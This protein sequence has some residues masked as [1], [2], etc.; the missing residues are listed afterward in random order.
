[1]VI[2]KNKA[3]RTIMEKLRSKKEKIIEERHKLTLIEI[4]EKEYSDFEKE[5]IPILIEL[6]EQ[7]SEKLS[8]D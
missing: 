5:I 7:A 2:V 4:K 1:M 3:S 8:P 6:G